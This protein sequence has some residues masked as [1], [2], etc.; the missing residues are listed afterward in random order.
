MP[1]KVSVLAKSALRRRRNRT[2]R[3]AQRDAALGNEQ[4][5]ASGGSGASRVRTED[6]RERERS[7]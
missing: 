1:P 2:R 3:K 7:A 5:G 4:K 6:W